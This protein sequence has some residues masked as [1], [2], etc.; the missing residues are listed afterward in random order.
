MLSFFTGPVTSEL[1]ERKYDRGLSRLI[2]ALAGYFSASEV[3]ACCDS[4]SL[5]SAPSSKVRRR[6]LRAGFRI[7]F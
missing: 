2:H 5:S 4:P 7:S 1:T 3:Q 6:P